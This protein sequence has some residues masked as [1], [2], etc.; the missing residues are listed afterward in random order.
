MVH[1]HG[2]GFVALS[3]FSTQNH[4][5]KWSKA[6]G[7]PIFSIDYRL[8]PQSSFP[9]A[10]DDTWFVYN[11]LVNHAHRFMNV[12]PKKIIVGGDSA[13]GNLAL[14][15]TALLMKKNITPL[16]YGVYLAYP[17]TDFRPRFSP[18]RIHSLDDT[19]LF[20]TLLYACRD[21]YVGAADDTNPL[22]SPL[23]LTEGWITG[24]TDPRW[25]LKWPKTRIIVG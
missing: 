20:A 2:G 6:F 17:A 22:L 7:I 25:P 10:L 15:L 13:G 11:F 14:T 3:S 1:T 5:R 12:R 9:D 19:L 8:T 16:P 23:L 24:G 21:A 18:S 4:T